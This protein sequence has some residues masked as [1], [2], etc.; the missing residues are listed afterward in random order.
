[1]KRALVLAALCLALVPAGCGGGNSN[2]E[3]LSGALGGTGKQDAQLLNRYF[4][5]IRSISETDI[6]VVKAFNDVDIE[7]AR[8]GV[9]RLH[10]IGTDSLSVA[11]DFSGAKLR[12]LFVDYSESIRKVADAYQA[13]IDADPGTTDR[14]F[15]ALQKDLIKRKQHLASLDNKLLV[16]LK[17]VMPKDQYAKLQQH[18][19]DL[20]K[21]YNDAAG[22]G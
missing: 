15:K 21:R 7:A 17:D 20:Q 12:T 11:Q 8:T 18:V 13:F 3:K 22:G 10:K 14:E 2:D 9:D 16:V 1:M 4:T 6:A 5:T 19:N